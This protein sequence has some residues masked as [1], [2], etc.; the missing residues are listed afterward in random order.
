MGFGGKRTCADDRLSPSLL[1]V[2]LPWCFAELVPVAVAAEDV[3]TAEQPAA[4][5]GAQP[6]P[7]SPSSAAAAPSPSAPDASA[8]SAATPPSQSTAASPMP[9]A[10]PVI[11]SIRGKLG[12]ASLRKG[13]D[14]TDL[15]ALEAFYAERSD[16][17]VWIT[18][19]GFSA[20]AQAA[21]NEIGKA[22]DWGLTASAFEP[23]PAGDLPDNAADQAIAE[24]KLQLAILKYARF[25]RGGRVDPSSLSVLIDQAPPLLDP[26]IVLTEIAASSTPDNYLQSLHPKHEQFQRLRQALLKA[27]ETAKKP[28]NE[29]EIQRLLINMERWRWMPA[30][31]GTVY[32]Q[33]N[34]PEFM[35]YVVKNGKT[36]HSDKIAVG[37]LRYATPIFS[38][39]MQTIV[40]N[41]EWTAPPT[42]VRED[43][44]PNLR[45]GGLFGGSSIL[46]QHGLQVKY[47]GRTVDPG[48]INWN[49]VNMA[50][51]A[52]TQPPGPRNVLGKVKFLYPNKHIV[53]MHDTPSGV[54]CSSRRCAPSAITA[55]AWRSRAGLRK[56]C[57]RK[58]RA[59]THR[60]SRISSTRAMTA[61]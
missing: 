37:E 57:S 36:I 58:T 5:L 4:A 30:D 2:V 12:D 13:A 10:D 1:L 59:G 56:F 32:V 18:G 39:D 24:I 29:Q 8:P 22:D 55:F 20:K 11:A 60:R 52:F 47:N 40:F 16:P 51:I 48:S 28:R 31:L 53:Y 25:A 14:V 45:R 35:L 41:P 26:K 44:L 50:N 49:S 54:T 61:R 15:A 9:A 21:V 38:A 7:T 46:R 19:M 6:N 34:V 17:P 23:P 3:A 33:D 42:V 43:L 27:R